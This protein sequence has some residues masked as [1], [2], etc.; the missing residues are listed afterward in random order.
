MNAKEKQ[1]IVNHIR[2][3]VMRNGYS[4]SPAVFQFKCVEWMRDIF[5]RRSRNIKSNAFMELP[6]LLREEPRLIKAISSGLLVDVARSF[7][8]TRTQV[9]SAEGGIGTSGLPHRSWHQDISYLG[10]QPIGLTAI[11]YLDKT[12]KNSGATMVIPLN[13]LPKSEPRSRFKPDPREKSLFADPGDVLFLNTSLW[14][15]GSSTLTLLEKRRMLVVSYSFWWVKTRYDPRRLPT[16]ITR[17]T[18]TE[19]RNL[20]G[21]EQPTGDLFIN[22]KE[23]DRSSIQGAKK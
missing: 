7:F 11:I 6:G 17:S 5:N 23:Y 3:G 22:W 21:I 8:G 4:L 1:I 18:S 20:W 14:H 10:A 15:T 19:L 13:V 9:I 2:Q 12:H 16:S